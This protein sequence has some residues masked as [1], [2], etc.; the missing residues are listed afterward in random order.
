MQLLPWLVLILA[1]ACRNFFWLGDANLSAVLRG[2]ENSL[3]DSKLELR[4]IASASLAGLVK[5]LP[6]PQAAQLRTHLLDGAAKLFPAR[7]LHR[8][9]ASAAAETADGI[10]RHACV[11]GLRALL[12]SSPHRIPAWMNEVLLAVVRAAQCPPPVKTTAVKTLGDFRKTHENDESRPLQ[13]RL[14]SDTWERL[15]A[16]AVQTSYFA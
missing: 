15:V 11:L 7:R 2:F 16:V 14:P 6:E 13:E 4:T 3:E 8:A 9:A 12:Q 5:A 10:K 1:L